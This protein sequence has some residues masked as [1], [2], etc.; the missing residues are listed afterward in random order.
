MKS[1]FN[2]KKNREKHRPDKVLKKIKHSYENNCHKLL[3][4]LTKENSPLLNYN[5][6]SQLSFLEMK[7]DDSKK[8]IEELT[9]L[10][11]YAVF[12]MEVSKKERIKISKN[13]RLYF[14]YYIENQLSRIKFFLEDFEFG[15]LKTTN[16]VKQSV[17]IIDPVILTLTYLRNYFELELRRIKSLPRVTYLTGFQVSMGPFLLKLSKLGVK[18][19]DQIT[20]IKNL[21]DDFKVDWEV[22]DR[23]NIK[24]S[25][26]KP[27]QNYL[28]INQKYENNIMEPKL[29]RF[30][31]DDLISNFIEQAK[32]LKDEFKRF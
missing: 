18:Q 23:E 29:T 10:L 26:L 8:L 32:V 11:Q 13:M 5:Y 31:S 9:T 1:Y 7:K 3:S 15:N 20:I 2:S 14:R 6:N 4:S 27:A 16:N 28:R 22:L 21:F 19:K 12:F 30:Y 24:L 25:I 17:S